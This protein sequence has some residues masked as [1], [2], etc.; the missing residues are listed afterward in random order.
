LDGAKTGLTVTP[1]ALERDRA[2]YQK[3]SPQWKETDED[4]E[5]LQKF[6][7]NATHVRR[8]KSLGVF[9][10]DT[11]FAQAKEESVRRMGEVRKLFDS[12]ASGRDAIDHDVTAPWFEARR[13]AERYVVEEGC[14]RMQR[15]LQ[16]IEKHVEEIYASHR[17]QL[18][19]AP[20]SPA[21]PIRRG[22]AAFTDLPIEARQDRFRA[23]SRRFVC[24]PKTEELLLDDR[25][26]SRLKASCA[27]WYDSQ[28]PK[29]S[30]FP[31][32]VAMREL[33]AIKAHALGAS[34]TVT[35]V[36]YERFSIKRTHR[37]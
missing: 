4:R 27:Y 15:D 5:L 23:L 10:M 30:R 34:K 32:D 11:I 16:K 28:Q 31:W 12:W 26:I 7:S 22:G 14:D 9:I 25:E 17:Q 21:A 33:C 24:A 6:E 37:K 29:W 36:F 8:P 2:K 19:A 35:I 1:E 13:I 3:R 20:G 18:R